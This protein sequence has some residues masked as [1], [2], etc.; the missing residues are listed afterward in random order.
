VKEA[1]GMIPPG[2]LINEDEEDGVAEKTVAGKKNK[3]V[4]QETGV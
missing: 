1:I 4:D 3:L 2:K